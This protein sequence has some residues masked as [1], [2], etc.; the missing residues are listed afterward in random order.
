MVAPQQDT[1][2]EA[3]LDEAEEAVLL[4]EELLR[5]GDVLETNP[6]GFVVCQSITFLLRADG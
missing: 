4:P 2:V 3:I 1:R 6:R 5:F